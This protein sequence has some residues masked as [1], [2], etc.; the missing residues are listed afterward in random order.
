M[1]FP[2]K[3]DVDSYSFVLTTVSEQISKGSKCILV[4]LTKKMKLPSCVLK[5]FLVRCTRKSLLSTF[6][7]II[8]LFKM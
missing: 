1:C 2:W 8:K 4:F 3:N 5:D 6:M 7:P